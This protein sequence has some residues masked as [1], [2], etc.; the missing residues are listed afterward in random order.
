MK[1]SR[2]FFSLLLVP[3]MLVGNF[4]PA[5]GV[6][7]T[8]SP[9]SP[10]ARQ[11]LAS[12]PPGGMAN[13]VITLRDQLATPP[14]GS[15]GLS[16]LQVAAGLPSKAARQQAV[17][18]ALQAHASQQQAGLL[19]QASALQAQ[20][21]V[22][23][24]IP[25]WI[26]NGVSLQATPAAIQALAARPEIA[27]IVPDPDP[28]NRIVPLDN[29][30]TI[31]SGA[32]PHS[33]L[34]PAALSAEPN[35]TLVNAPALWALGY[36]GQGVVIA[37]LDTGVS[38]S[39]PELAGSYRG[40][41]NSWFD[42][43][44]QNPTPADFYG[45]GTETMGIMLGSGDP[46]APSLIGMAP[47]AKWISA[48]IFD[49]STS[50]TT[51]AVHQA[52]QWVMDP[53]NNPANTGAPDVV[54]NSWGDTAAGCDLTF[55]PDVTALL[56]AGILPVF[57]AGNIS[58]GAPRDVS[59]ANNAGA[60][61][62]GAVDN[63]DLIASFSSTGPNS[64]NPAQQFPYVVAP[65]VSI[66]TSFLN[67]T[68]AVSSGTSF[69]APHVSGALALLLSAMPYLAPDLQQQALIQGAH[70]LGSPS[71]NVTYGYGRLDALASFN[72]LN[73]PLAIPAGLALTVVPP[74]QIDLAWSDPNAGS[75]VYE[76]GRSTDKK[77]WTLVDT[78][79]AGATSYSDNG[80][81]AATRYYYRLRAV[82]TGAGTS[83]QYAGASAATLAGVLQ[84]PTGLTA[85]AA[86]ATQVDLSWVN[87]SA[88]ATAIELDRSPNGL[89]G[90]TTLA[91]AL[92]PT[93]SS[94][95]DS[96]GLSEGTPYFYRVRALDPALSLG[97]PYATASATTLLLPPT[98]LAAAG[99]APDQIN[100]SW[101]DNSA[102]ATGYEVQRSL[103]GATGWTVLTTTSAAATSYSDS[104]A[105]TLSENGLY[106]YRVRAVGTGSSSTFA[107]ASARTLLK[108]P[109]G[110]A[111]VSV[112]PGQVDLIWVNNSAAAS[113]YEIQ[114]SPDGLSWSTLTTI[115]SPTT[116]YSDTGGLSEGTP[117]V[118][119]VRAVGAASVSLFT[120]VDVT[121]LLLA[122]T[123]LVAIPVSA[124]RIDLH[125]TNHSLAAAGV[126]VQRSPDYG[127]SGWTTVF[128]SWGGNNIT[129]FSDASGLAQGGIYSYRVRALS[130][131]TDSLFCP[132]EH[133]VF[134]PVWI[135]VPSIFK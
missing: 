9:F 51:T 123:G 88:S 54:N 4:L 83:S 82:N 93:T 20:G 29:F 97:S 75:A 108:A 56:A 6:G 124:S 104:D 52:F 79:P 64:C 100:L 74:T 126:E 95:S 18:E 102:H 106:F 10:S 129:S 91:A 12:L 92:P 118:Y 81:S 42:P 61:A 80:L 125:W 15:A 8:A 85:A 60:F 37:S 48:K 24:I 32:S 43:Y 72:Y 132:P 47:G 44:G 127:L 17:I 35:L 25:F 86:S 113:G 71:P 30:P 105:L 49:N 55:Q 111:A 59:P 7:P 23:R 19:A 109:S 90:W 14:A 53:N 31:A 13:F 134:G 45:H 76:I 50:A 26:F 130:A 114:R 66:R 65:G 107:S 117:Y 103:D 120:S 135:Y 128:F 5:A 36:T 58:S 99:V 73:A 122:P 119:R 1:S 33:A 67:N 78:T 11:A 40:G 34:A 84:A 62:V 115:S 63:N 112:A 41:A 57:S 38:G 68:Y 16:P 98:G 46:A 69:S 3:L 22:G 121:T 39:H 87:H 96:S 28:S 77:T 101:V 116:S 133:V 27:S 94:Y 21:A 70:P 110:L 2:I 89:T 131:T